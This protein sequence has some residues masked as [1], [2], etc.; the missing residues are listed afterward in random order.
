MLVEDV[1]GMGHLT[2]G[3]GGESVNMLITLTDPKP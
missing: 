2:R 1:S 3:V